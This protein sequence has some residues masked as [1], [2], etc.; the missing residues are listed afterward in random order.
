MRACVAKKQKEGKMMGGLTE[1]CKTLQNISLTESL[2]RQKTELEARLSKV[3][4]ALEAL[5][6]NPEIAE[7]VNTISRIGNI[8]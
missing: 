6:R 4:K 2:G 3:N 5:K 8:Y 1:S 7:V